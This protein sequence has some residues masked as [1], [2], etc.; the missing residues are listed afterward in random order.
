MPRKHH[1]TTWAEAMDVP[2]EDGKDARLG[3]IMLVTGS[4]EG[5]GTNRGTGNSWVEF[6]GM[7]PIGDW[8][9]CR[10]F[11]YKELPPGTTIRVKEGAWRRKD[12]RL[13]IGEGWGG[14]EIVEG[15]EPPVVEDPPVGEFDFED[16]LVNT[17]LGMSVL[18]RDLNARLRKLEER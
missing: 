3:G 6:Q 16:H 9:M 12:R 18:F 13:A 11:D 10:W 5:E 2:Q 7:D 1:V 4:K 15:V 8:R 17:V 14:L